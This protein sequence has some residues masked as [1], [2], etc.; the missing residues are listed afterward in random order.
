MP[1]KQ[2]TES[3][4]PPQKKRK[5]NNEDDPLE[6]AMNPL[7]IEEEI[8][9]AMKQKFKRGENNN[10]D[11]SHLETQDAWGCDSDL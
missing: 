5:R 7:E 6:T 2:E 4:G 11:D 9:Y 8:I 1:I 10:V 3:P